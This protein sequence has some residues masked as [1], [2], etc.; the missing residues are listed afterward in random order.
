MGARGPAPKPQMLKSLEGNP[1]KRP[2][3]PDAP[4][5]MGVPIP[6]DYLSDEARTVW[7][8]ILESLPPGMITQADEHL[9]AAYCCQVEMHWQAMV[10]LREN[11]NLLGEIELVANGRPSPYLRIMMDAARN[12]AT[13]G[14]RLGLSPSDRNGLRVIGQHQEDSKWAGLLA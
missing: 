12:L 9:L 1:G 10:A 7:F 14:S 3:N 2:L 4:T 8:R 6:P 5:P 13:L 11:R